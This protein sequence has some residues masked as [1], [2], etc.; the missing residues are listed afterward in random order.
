[1]KLVPWSKQK[2]LIVESDDFRTAYYTMFMEIYRISYDIARTSSRAI[3]KLEN[4]PSIAFVIL[5][6]ALERASRRGTV[7]DYITS[8]LWRPKEGKTFPRFVT[9]SDDPY[10]VYGA[11]AVFEKKAFFDVLDLR[12]AKRKILRLFALQR[13]QNAQ[14]QKK[15]R[16]PLR[17]L[18]RPLPSWRAMPALVKKEPAA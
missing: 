2:V 3:D 16:K 1:M 4:D 11:S 7:A 10:P 9:A 12:L 15:E 5:D 6:G 8:E 17:P 14:S 18:K 13:H